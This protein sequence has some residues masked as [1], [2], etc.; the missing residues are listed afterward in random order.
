VVSQEPIEVAPNDLNRAYLDAKREK[1][2]HTI[3]RKLH[4]QRLRFDPDSFEG[5]EF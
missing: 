4:H 5:A 1:L 2:G 3:G